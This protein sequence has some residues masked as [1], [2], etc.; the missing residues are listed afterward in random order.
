MD[1]LV[2][3]KEMQVI[4]ITDLTEYPLNIRLV[5][6][7]VDSLVTGLTL[8]SCV[9]EYIWRQVREHGMKQQDAPATVPQTCLVSERQNCSWYAINDRIVLISKNLIKSK[10]E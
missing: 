6:E 8:S 10:L 9:Y 3:I 1:A 7:T 5:R 4:I 2:F